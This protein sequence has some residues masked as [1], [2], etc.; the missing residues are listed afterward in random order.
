[1]LIKHSQHPERPRSPG[2][3]RF[4]TWLQHPFAGSRL[5]R[6]TRRRVIRDNDD[7]CLLVAYYGT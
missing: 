5:R 4:F 7:L 1:M 6:A 2:F 3:D